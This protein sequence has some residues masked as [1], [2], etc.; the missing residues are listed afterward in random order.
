V[1]YFE[2]NILAM[3]DSLF[4]KI[5]RGEIPSH[6]VYEDDKTFAFLDIHPI[7]NGQVLVVPKSQIDHIW[8]LTDEDYMALW[9]VVKKIANRMREQIPDKHRIGI[10]VE[11]FDVP[12]AHVKVFPINSG[13][14]LRHL[15]DMSA[16]P[17]HTKLA[18]MAKKLAF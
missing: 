17:D 9:L 14:E 4:S 12:H 7:Q 10:I 18:E 11:G 6:K 3:A 5:I 15:P 8:D 1:E 16:E 2:P 13:D